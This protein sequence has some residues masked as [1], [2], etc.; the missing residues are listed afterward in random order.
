MCL[1]HVSFTPK[2]G[3]RPCHMQF[4]IVPT[5]QVWL[6]NRF[7]INHPFRELEYFKLLISFE[8]VDSRFTT[9]QISCRGS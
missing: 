5:L 7:E 1:N 6:E 8:S 3:V 9:K 2:R 4:L